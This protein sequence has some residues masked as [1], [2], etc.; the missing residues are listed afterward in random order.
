VRELPCRENQHTDPISPYG[1]SKLAAERYCVAF[2]RVYALETV[3][4][5]Y[6]NVFGP[7]QD[8]TS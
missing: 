3:S 5:R 6:F 7:N 8:P 2:S 1:V 4:L